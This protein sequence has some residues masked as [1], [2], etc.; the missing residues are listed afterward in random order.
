[1][2]THGAALLG[3]VGKLLCSLTKKPN[4]VKIATAGKILPMQKRLPGKW[5][6]RQLRNSSKV[7]VLSEEIEQEAHALGVPPDAITRLPNGVDTDRFTPLTAEQ[8]TSLRTEKRLEEEEQVLLFSGRL[9]H[10]KGLDLVLDSWPAISTAY[11]GAHLWILGNGTNQEEAVEGKLKQR[12]LTEELPHIHWLGETREPE[13]FLQSADVFVFPSRREG[14]SNT[15]LEAMACA[16]PTVASNIGGNT[17]VMIDGANG[18]L[19]PSDN[20]DLLEE[21]LLSLL[22]SEDERKRLEEQAREDVIR[23]Y[24]I[25]S[26]AQRYAELYKELA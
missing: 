25:A 9:V 14:F 17:D 20:A 15:L 12:V 8:R 18:L 26:I 7:I 1:M 11:P 22:G 5:V 10:R 2:H 16:L 19:F 21:K 24:S 3:A 4:V 23:D 13:S 6:L